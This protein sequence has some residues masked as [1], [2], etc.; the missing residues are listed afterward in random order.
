MPLRQLQHHPHHQQVSVSQVA[1]FVPSSMSAM[2]VPCPSSQVPICSLAQSV[3]VQFH[4]P[5]S[6][7]PSHADDPFLVLFPSPFLS[8]AVSSVAVVVTA[9]V[10]LRPWLS[11]SLL[12]SVPLSPSSRPL[13]FLRHPPSPSSGLRP[14]SVVVAAVAPD[15]SPDS[16]PSA[17]VVSLVANPLAQE[18]QGI[19]ARTVV[20]EP[21]RA[22]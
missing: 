3:V 6:L 5:S 20:L 13:P 7:S 8:L 12:S 16:S 4:L 15:T 22:L 19:L 11:Q 1:E 10:F 2:A 14:V 17:V 9:L 18:A 21:S